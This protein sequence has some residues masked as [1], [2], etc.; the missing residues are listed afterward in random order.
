MTQQKVSTR[1]ATGLFTIALTI[2]ATA[3]R[4][5]EGATRQGIEHFELGRFED[6]K[7]AFDVA[8][9]QNQ[10]DTAALFYLGRIAMVRGDF[11][12]AAKLLERATKV[13]GRTAEHFRWLGQAYAQQA[14][15]GSKIKAAFIAKRA[16]VAF[17]RAVSLEQDNVE[18]RMALLRYYLLAPGMM[19]GST[20]RAARQVPEIRKRSPYW[21]RLAAAGV[22]EDRKDIAAAER[23]Y[24]SAIEEFPDS[25]SALYAL[26]LL[27]QRAEQHEKAFDAFER[28]AAAF[29]NESNAL[30]AI[31]RL[32]AHTG[33]RLERA[34]EALKLFLSKPVKEG[35]VPRSSAHYRLGT[36]YEKTG[37]RDLAR[38][39]YEASLRLEKRSEVREALAR[40]K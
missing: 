10:R 11:D 6:A 28:M 36:V 5:Q 13:D 17:E 15:R 25:A 20:E 8:I 3:L 12:D 26:G 9:G 16:K 31:G 34:E 33:Q 4:A 32:G 38:K 23:E 37:R 7:K 14:V 40:L 24:L 18:A 29:P 35:D 22:H 27:Y 39:E 19:G 30:Y 1:I 21:G 2:G